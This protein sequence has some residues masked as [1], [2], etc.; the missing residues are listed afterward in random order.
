MTT[1]F[2]LDVYPIIEVECGCHVAGAPAGLAMGPTALD[3][4]SNLVGVAALQSGFSRIEPGTTEF[5][6][7]WHKINDTHVGPPAFGAGNP[8]PPPMGGLDPG[9][10]TTIEQWILDGAPF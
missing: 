5:S 9:S 2:D 7:L 3:A 1:S 4:Y 6:Y 8:M 10:L